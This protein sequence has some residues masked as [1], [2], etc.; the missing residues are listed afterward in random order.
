MKRFVSLMLVLCCCLCLLA[1]CGKQTEAV[2]V[3]L[4]FLK[5]P[6]GMGAVKLFRDAEEGKTAI[7]YEKEIFAS[8]NDLTGLLINGEVDIAALPT[9]AAAALF[10]KTGGGVTL[11]AINTLG[12]L[13]VLEKGDAVHAINDLAGRQLASSGQNATP[14]YALNYLL[15]QNNVSDCKTVYYAEHTEVVANALA[16]KE[17]LVLLPEPQ[18]TILQTKDPAWHIALDINEVWNTCA[19]SAELSMGCV[20]VRT[21]FLQA[22]PAAV[23]T[24]LK[25]YAASVRYVNE[26]L[27][28]SAALIADYGIVPDAS[29]A[30]KAIPT[31]KIVCITGEDMAERTA[32]YLNILYESDPAF[33]G[34]RIPDESFYYVG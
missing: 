18:A 16:G 5:G 19:H 2:T 11:L 6:T 21:Q 30:E 3:N 33:I 31:S 8:P 15:T 10:N 29:L 32:A 22:H 7:K 4:G 20:A 17:D 9:N 25:E 26:N 27:R 1:G 34:G 23:S 13:F 24:F 14:E 12:T 28:E